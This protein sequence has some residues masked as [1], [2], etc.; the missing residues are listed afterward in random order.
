MEQVRLLDLQGR[1][2][3][4]ARVCVDR[5]FLAGLQSFQPGFELRADRHEASA[6]HGARVQVVAFRKTRP[7]LRR[8]L[9]V[10]L[11]NSIRQISSIGHQFFDLK[12]WTVRSRHYQRRLIRS[13]TRRKMCVFSRSTRV[14]ANS[15]FLLRANFSEF[16]RHFENVRPKIS[17]M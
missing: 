8:I 15:K 4:L 2:S 9:F 10:A 12:L 17:K 5:S 11:T 13:N 3:Q 1:D 14:C 6:R 7:T 16:L